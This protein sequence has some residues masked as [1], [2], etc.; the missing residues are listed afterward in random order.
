MTIAL[1]CAAFLILLPYLIAAYGGYYRKQTFGVMDNA[2][3]RQQASQL[4]GYGAR[5]YAAQQNSWENAIVFSTTAMIISLAGLDTSTSQLICLTF[6]ALR[7][8]HP[9]VYLKN[10]PTIRS[11]VNTSGL[12]CCTALIIMAARL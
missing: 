2:N 7:I 9:I 5:I 3:P 8:T 1:W 6:V 4:E 10:L 12:F 11:F